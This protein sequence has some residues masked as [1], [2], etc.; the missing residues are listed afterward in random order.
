MKLNE[1][2]VTT[3]IGAVTSGFIGASAIDMD[4]VTTLA[5]LA[6]TSDPKTLVIA[7]AIFYIF[8]RMGRK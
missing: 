3:A 4:T 7:A 6:A 8:K 2:N 1:D 5:G